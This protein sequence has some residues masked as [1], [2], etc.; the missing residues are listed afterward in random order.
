MYKSFQIDVED[1][2]YKI[3]KKW[4]RLHYFTT[5][6]LV[7][8]AF[9]LE[10]IIGRILY[11]TG[12][13]STTITI[14]LLKFFIMPTLINSVLIFI[15]YKVIHT[16]RISQNTKIYTVSLILVAICFLISIVHSAFSSLFFIFA[17][18]ILLTSIYGIYK[19]STITGT[20][21]ISALI[22]SELFIKWDMDKVSV[23]ESGIRLGNFLI[24]VFVL[25]AFFAISMIIIYF[26]KAK[27]AASM[28]KDLERHSL[29]QRIQ[30][31][32][33][34]DINNRIAFRNEISKMEEDGSDNTYIFV[35][36]DL[37]NFKSLNDKYGHVEGDNCLIEFGRILKEKSGSAIPFRY[38]GDEFSILF[39][40]STIDEVIKIC[41]QIQHATKSINTNV[42]TDNQVTAS[43][44]IASY[45]KEMSP[46]T[47]ISNSDEALYLSKKQKNMITVYKDSSSDNLNS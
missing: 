13:I 14:Y 39:K 36:I 10:S 16:S 27:N 8:I 33:L 30:I 40:N 47:L 24:S 43:F 3:D 42:K 6:G 41:E 38:G 34:T 21:S 5:I 15:D 12:E 31:D 28:K 9:L 26:E 23:F 35:M 37:D 29:R 18:P 44:G 32:E 46:S 11:L 22:I 20:L 17:V 1:E 2:Y 4:L 45:S 7:L 25:M 19:L